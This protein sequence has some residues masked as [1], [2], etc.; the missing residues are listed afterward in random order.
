MKILFC[1]LSVFIISKYSPGQQQWLW[2]YGLTSQN[3]FSKSIATDLSG[4]VYLAGQFYGTLDFDPGPN[5]HYLTAA[6][7]SSA[8]DAFIMK[9]DANGNYLWAYNIGSNALDYSTDVTT[10][11]AG[12]IYMLGLFSDTVDFDPGPGVTQFIT[13][14]YIPE[15]FILKLN[16][17]GNFIWARH[18]GGPNSVNPQAIVS[19]ANNNIYT[20]GFFHMTSDFDPGPGIL[21]LNSTGDFDIYVLKLN[22]AGNLVWGKS[23]GGTGWD[24]PNGIAVDPLGNVFLTGIFHDTADF[25]PGPGIVNL[26]T[27]SS[28]GD[29]FVCK[30]NSNGSL[31]WSGAIGLAGNSQGNS[32]SLDNNCNVYSTGYFKDTADFDPSPSVFQVIPTGM[33]DAYVNKL[34]STGNFIWSKTLHCSVNNYVEGASLKVDSSTND[35]I[36]GGRFTGQADFDPS[37]LTLML[38]CNTYDDGFIARYSNTGDLVWAK[39][40]GGP[41]G[42]GVAS[43]ALSG[44][45]V[46]TGTSGGLPMHF[47]SLTVSG[48][49]FFA[50]SVAVISDINTPL[51]SKNIKVYPNPATNQLNVTFANPVKRTRLKVTDMSGRIIIESFVEENVTTIPLTDF[52]NG[53]YLLQVQDDLQ[54]SIIRFVISR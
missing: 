20:T 26:I 39:S 42:E 1:F 48:V 19:D 44:G 52:E 31:A 23:M 54:Q 25:D 45:I 24:Q 30:L 46:L 11:N 29:A 34:D 14:P 49:S 5:T 22:S 37:A 40:F 7:T 4:N 47:D 6:G 16:S 50:K 28:S 18:F 36:I 15:V 10:D 35:V 33:R 8:M 38:T 41:S 2:S 53:M 27:Q 51:E 21:N 17:N 9:L 3:V 12:N 32:V 13:D 43:I